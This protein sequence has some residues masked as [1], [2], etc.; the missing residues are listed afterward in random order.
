MPKTRK[1]HARAT[2]DTARAMRMPHAPKPKQR[3]SHPAKA[4]IIV[5]SAIV[6]AGA[7]AAGAVMMRSQIGRLAG[8]AAEE[9]MAAGHKVGSLGTR[10]GSSL[11]RDQLG[12]LLSYA[13]FSRRRSLVSRLAVPMGIAGAVL[14]A[15]GS[16]VFLL[17][18][19]LAPASE[20]SPERAIGSRSRSSSRDS[21]P[22]ANSAGS[23]GEREE[24]A[25]HAV[26]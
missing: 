10:I 21:S 9:A 13:G 11:N 3:F 7:A 14:A 15:A 20:E 25:A 17:M 24:A 19:R 1:S 26:K 16:A 2:H 23:I 4:S 5:G 18:P 8:D 12:Q 22:L 6:A